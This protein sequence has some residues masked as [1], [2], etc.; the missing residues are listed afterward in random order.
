MCQENSGNQGFAVCQPSQVLPTYENLRFYP[1]MP[2]SGIVGKQ[3]N[4]K[5]SRIFPTYKK[6]GLNLCA[7]Q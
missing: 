7:S 4:W 1:V 3:R 6:Q 2:K 5:S